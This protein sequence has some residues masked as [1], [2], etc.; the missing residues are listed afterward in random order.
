MQKILTKVEKLINSELT[1]K[2]KSSIVENDELLIEID[3]NNLIEVVQFL[4]SNE[5]CKFR[6]L[7]DIVGVDYPNEEHDGRWENKR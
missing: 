3:V 5:S 1:S 6:Q 2:V 4:K 7:I